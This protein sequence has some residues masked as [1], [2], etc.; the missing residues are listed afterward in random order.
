[1]KIDHM[2]LYVLVCPCFLEVDLDFAD[3]EHI[4]KPFQS[5]IGIGQNLLFWGYHPGTVGFR[6]IAARGTEL[7]EV[8]RHGHQGEG[9]QT[10]CITWT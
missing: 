6:L 1:M 9:R 3:Q 2:S 10:Q 4:D 5:Y 7:C 8:L